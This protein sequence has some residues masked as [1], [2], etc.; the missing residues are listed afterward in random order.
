MKKPLYK[1]K[2]GPF[3]CGSLSLTSE[4]GKW[5]AYFL[6]M[7]R[8][9]PQCSS[10][11]SHHVRNGFFSRTNFKPRI[12]RYRCKN[13]QK[14][15]SDATFQLRYRQR[16]RSVNGPV[17]RLLVTGTS[18][19]DIAR[20][21]KINR[22]TVARKLIYLSNKAQLENNRLLKA[23]RSITQVQMD[24]MES[25]EH[26]KMKPLSITIA[27]EKTHR[28][29]LGAKVSTMPAK[30]LLA[31]RARK[32]Y[33]KR[34]D[35]RASARNKLLSELVKNLSPSVIFETDQHPHY[36]ISITKYF[37]RASHQ[38][39]K[40]RRGCVVGQGELKAGGFDP[41]FS[42]N[43]TCAMLRYKISRLI[44]RTWVTTKKLENLQ[45]HIDI[46]IVHHNKT[47]IPSRP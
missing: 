15:F 27:V 7:K 8:K 17:E 12:Q 28:F 46:Y 41:L 26:T 38:Q 43:H 36:G 11:S 24:D 16:R 47:L 29:I 23:C 3:N 6:D 39:Y 31:K 10:S 19:R 2:T 18:L 37:P 34:S 42:L 14:E 35:G 4:P 40:G 5:F 13:C 33:G 32:K 20:Q 44:R 30:G 25:F 45:R 9:C 21:L 22:K 1:L